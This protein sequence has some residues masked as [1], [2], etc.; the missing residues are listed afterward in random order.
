MNSARHSNLSE[1]L[2]LV[3][4]KEASEIAGLAGV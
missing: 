1:I 2:Q 3:A 4:Q